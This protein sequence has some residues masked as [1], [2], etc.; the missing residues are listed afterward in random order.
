[1]LQNVFSLSVP[2]VFGHAA[3]KKEEVDQTQ[4]W[5]A[6]QGLLRDRKVIAQKLPWSEGTPEGCP[7]SF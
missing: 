3:L 2:A 4:W 5:A 7:G 1:M 6:K